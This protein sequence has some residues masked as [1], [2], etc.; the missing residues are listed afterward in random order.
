MK[1]AEEAR[2]ELIGMLETAKVPVKGSYR[3]HEVCGILSIC[4]RTFQTLVDRFEPDH[5]SGEPLRP[6]SLDS[7]M[8][9]NER[10]V[11]FNEL[12]SYLQ[13]NNTYHRKNAIDPRQLSLF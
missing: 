4:R 10:R 5:E 2:E 3:R 7:Y 1:S 11:Q 8:L 13:R 6:D 12:V 9:Q